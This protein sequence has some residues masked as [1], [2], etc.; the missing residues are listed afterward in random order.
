MSTPMLATRPARPAGAVDGRGSRAAPPACPRSAPGHVRRAAPVRANAL[1]VAQSVAERWRVH[2]CAERGA[3]PGGPG[4]G[5]ASAT[6]RP[7]PAP[8]QL[9]GDLEV[10]AGRCRRRGRGAPRHS[11]RAHQRLRGT[12]GHHP[13]Q[14]P[15][16]HRVRVLAGTRRDHDLTR[17]ESKRSSVPDDAD[18][19]PVSGRIGERAP[20]RGPA[21]DLDPRR[22]DP[23]DERPPVRILAVGGPGAGEVETRREL[24]VELPA[25]LGALVDHGD[26]RPGAG[27][28]LG[29]ARPPGPRRGEHPVRRSPPP[30]PNRGRARRAA[31]GWPAAPASARPAFRCDFSCMALVRPP[32]DPHEAVKADPHPQK[33][34]RGSSVVGAQLRMPA[35]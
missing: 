28:R 19:E 35:R 30:D 15:S 18:L 8:Y 4:R 16:R 11:V 21:Q 27:G 10:E 17:V 3:S 1:Q 26:L 13:G 6:A 29:A 14:R 32:V 7:H 25:G 24:L 20:H 23:L 34:P 12:G 5:A 2:E 31:V 9:T 22:P 33:T